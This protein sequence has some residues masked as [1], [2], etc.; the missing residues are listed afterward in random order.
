MIELES[1][2][3]FYVLLN[4]KNNPR[5]QWTNKKGRKYGC[6]MAK[7]MHDIMLKN[8]KIVV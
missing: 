1:F 6:G 3:D 7:N 2:K 8:T 5:K 4:V